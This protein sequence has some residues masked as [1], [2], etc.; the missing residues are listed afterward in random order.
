KWRVAAALLML[1]AADVARSQYVPSVPPGV[2]PVP[3][4]ASPVTP[5][6]PPPA[7]G[8]AQP[9]GAATAAEGR[10]QPQGWRVRP[11]IT[12]RETYTDNACLGQGEPGSDWVTL[13]TPGIRIDGRSRRFTADFAYTPSAV[14]YARNP[15]GNDVINNLDAFGRAEAIENF[16]FVEA[17]A[18]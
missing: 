2:S 1:A 16:F 10:L 8:T 7:P 14:F 3:S 18:K 4:G 17:K 11:E 5:G 15:E 13:V 12:L 6:A 9:D